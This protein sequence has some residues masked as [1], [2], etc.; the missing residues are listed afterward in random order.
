MRNDCGKVSKGNTKKLKSNMERKNFL[1]E[2]KESCSSLTAKEWAM[3]IAGV[4]VFIII[5]GL[6]G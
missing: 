3:E 4:V 6:C 5:C 2:L 1:A